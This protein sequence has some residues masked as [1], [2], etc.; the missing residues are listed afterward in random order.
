MKKINVGDIVFAKILDIENIQV[1]KKEELDNNYDY[2]FVTANLFFGTE[3][4]EMYEEKISRL[5]QENVEAFN[6]YKRWTNELVTMLKYDGNNTFTE[7]FTG[8]T[9]YYNPEFEDISDFEHF[10]TLYNY[11]KVN[12]LVIKKVMT[13]NDNLITQFGY[14]IKYMGN[15]IKDIMNSE[16]RSAQFIVEDTFNDVVLENDYINAIGTDCY[17]EFSRK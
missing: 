10:N 15:E 5:D 11:F 7:Y 2:H 8:A 9:V 13:K 6:G 17:R 16:Y 14:Q 4:T 1:E 3:F 12:P